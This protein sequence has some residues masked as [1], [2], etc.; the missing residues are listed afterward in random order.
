MKKGLVI[1]WYFP[2]INSSE[3]IVTFKLLKN[4][5]YEYDVFTQKGNED[6]SY[7]SNAD[8]LKSNNINTI[9]AKTNDI[10]KWVEEGIEYFENNKDKYDYIM[11]RSMAADSHKI[12]LE[13]KKRHPEVKWIASFGDPI[14]DNPYKNFYRKYN[15][16]SLNGKGLDS[17]SIKEALKPT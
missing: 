16:F 8:K 2:P 7:G 11:S 13:I 3:G 14:A 15:P 17:M 1:S 4:S 9:F 6:W 10:N 5:K 12:A